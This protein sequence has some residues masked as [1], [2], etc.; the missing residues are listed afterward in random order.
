M[1]TY[2]DGKAQRFRQ[3]AIGLAGYDALQEGL[4]VLAEYAVGG[5]SRPRLRLLAGRVLAVRHMVDG[6]TFVDTF[7]ELTR[8]H[9]FAQ[10]TAFT[11]TLRVYRGGGLTKDAVY[12]RGLAEI[13]EHLGGGGELEPLFVGKIAARHIPIVRELRWRNVLEDPPLLPRYLGAAESVERLAGLRKGATVL[14]LI[15]KKRKKR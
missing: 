8:T 12:L 13:L 2:F 9:G 4:A 3:L 15:E 11:V 14:D 7:R 1:V 5:L 6:A 10:R